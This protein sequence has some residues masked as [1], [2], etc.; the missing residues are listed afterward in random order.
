MKTVIQIENVSKRYSIRHEFQNPHASIKEI[1][2]DKLK[3]PFR[4]WKQPT[5]KRAA[6]V[7]DFWALRDLNFSIKEGE[8]IA[9]L[10]RNGA[11]KSTL[12]KLLSRITEPTHGTIKIKG[13]VCSL[14]EVGSG[15]HPELTGMENILFNGALMGMSYQ[16][17]RR[18]QDEIISFAEI[19]QFLHTPLKRYSSG[20]HMRL[21]F[22]IAAHLESEILIVDEALAVG[23][24]QFQEKCLKKIAEM[25][26]GRTIFFVSH[27]MDYALTL[28]D[29][30]IFLDRGRMVAFEPIQ[31]CVKRYEGGY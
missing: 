6:V 11:G 8:K 4:Y 13:R 22:A 30:G 12:L 16:E 14:L 20:M 2:T 29:K 21:G 28:C 10:G 26:H 18:K 3:Q 1:L 9:L 19:E 31:D 7:E 23:D 15:F 24:R 17:I 5:A 25:G 27:N